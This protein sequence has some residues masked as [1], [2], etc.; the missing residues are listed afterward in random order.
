MIYNYEEFECLEITEEEK[1][2]IQRYIGTFHTGMN[3][4]LDIDQNV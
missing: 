4:I 2:A 1:S 3:A